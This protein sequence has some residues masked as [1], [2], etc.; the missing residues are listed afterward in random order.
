MPKLAAFPKAF[1]DQLCVDG[2]MTVRQWIDL[3]ATL[4]IDGLEFYSGFLEFRVRANWALSRRIVE[5][6]GLT[7]PM[8]CCSPDFTHPDPAF[9]RQQVDLQRGWIDMAASAWRRNT[10]ACFPA[11]AGPRSRARMACTTRPREF[12]PACR[13]RPRRA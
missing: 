6:H 8:L 1:M 10:A 4:D 12:K 2:T 3:A 13:T 5:D 9:R 11:S 7:I